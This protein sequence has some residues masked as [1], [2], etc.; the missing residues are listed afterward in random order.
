ML[1]PANQQQNDVD[2]NA[3]S[4]GEKRLSRGSDAVKKT[5]DQH[6]RNDKIHTS[7]TIEARVDS[8]IVG[9]NNDSDRWHESNRER[10]CVVLLSFGLLTANVDIGVDGVVQT[11]GALKTMDWYDLTVDSTPPILTVEGIYFTLLFFTI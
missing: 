1:P 7:M 4:H 11:K 6:A 8:L 2:M 3:S 5:I 10:R 9:V